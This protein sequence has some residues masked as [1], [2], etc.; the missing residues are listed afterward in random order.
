M[1][2]AI[3]SSTL[4]AAKRTGV[5]HF[6][7]RLLASLF[8]LDTSSK[9]QLVYMSFVGRQQPSIFPNISN[10]SHKRISWLPGKAYNLLL[11]AR[12]APPIDLIANTKPDIFLFPNFIKWPTIHSRKTIVTVHDMSFIESP[13]TIVPRHRWFLK[14]FVPKSIAKS[15]HVITI[16]DSSKSQ[17]IKHYGTDPNKICVITPAIDHSF[18]KPASTSSVD[19]IKKKYHIRDKYLLYFGTIEPRKNIAGIIKAYQAL[20]ANI[21][22][23]H[24]LVLGGGSGWL[25]KE[26]N[27]LAGQLEPGELVKTGYLP[28]SDTPALY[29]GATVFLYPSLYE[30]WGMQILEAMACG[31]P[32][33]TADN[34]SLPE[35]G[36]NAAVYIKAQD[37]GALTREIINI[38]TNPSVA[39]EM[40]QAGLEHAD[41]FTWQNSARKLKELLE[42]VG[43]S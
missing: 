30:G 21:R 9:Y 8:E 35:A 13:D 16:S 15:D 18:F 34:S 3:E 1:K 4:I 17:I 42:S 22:N 2:I 6:T 31:T 20:P 38:V 29:T 24:Q 10:L 27:D 37:T 23:S 12:L 33:I 32:V 36:G 43:S 19:K 28:D 40:Q 5:E 7:H 25:D 11:R 39:R 14:T 41:R 26:I